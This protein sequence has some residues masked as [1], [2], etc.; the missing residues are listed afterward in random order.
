MTGMDIADHH[1][2]IHQNA[3]HEYEAEGGNAVDGQ[4]GQIGDE[5]CAQKGR[6]YAHAD[7]ES[8]AWT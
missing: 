5:D 7:P 8:Q 3:Q 2:V 6:G 4:T 1:R